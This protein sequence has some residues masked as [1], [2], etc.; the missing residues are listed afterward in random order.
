MEQ[1]LDFVYILFTK[2]SVAKEKGIIVEEANMG[3][4]DAYSI[5]FFHTLAILCKNLSIDILLQ[6]LQMM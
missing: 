5:V 1:L 6:V 3:L 2:K 4:D